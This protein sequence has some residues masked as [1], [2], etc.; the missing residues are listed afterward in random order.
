MAIPERTFTAEEF[1][2]FILLPEHGDTLFE[3]INGRVYPVVS[4]NRSSRIGASILIAVGSFVKANALGYVTGADGG[5]IVAGERL[6]PDL[7]FMSKV[8][9]P[10]RSKEAYNPLAPDLAVE[11]LSPS[12]DESNVRLKLTSYLSAETTVWIVNPDTRT[13]EIHLPNKPPIKL[14]ETDTIDGG[15]MLPGFTLPVS[16]IFEDE[17]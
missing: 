8:R 4:N 11:V 17:E 2:E 6:M 12:D 13:I 10:R 7:A 9:Q 3:L 16:E 1:D 5:Y 15:D 14:T